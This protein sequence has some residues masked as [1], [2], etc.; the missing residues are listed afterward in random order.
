LV[1]RIQTGFP[2]V[3]IEWTGDDRETMWIVGTGGISRVNWDLKGQ[4]LVTK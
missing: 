1:V 2:A 3:N 4:E